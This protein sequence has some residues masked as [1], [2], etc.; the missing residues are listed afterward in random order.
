MYA[1]DTDWYSKFISI[2]RNKFETHFPQVQVSRKRMNDKPWIT[3]GLKHSIRQNHRLY[4]STLRTGDF[5][6]KSKYKKYNSVLKKCLK[7]AESAYYME[8]FDDATQSTFNL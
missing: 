3:K 4:K 6:T 1:I 7:N 2:I 5:L 8:L